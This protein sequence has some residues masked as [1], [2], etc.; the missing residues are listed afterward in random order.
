MGPVTIQGVRMLRQW[1]SAVAALGEL[2]SQHGDEAREEAASFAD[3]YRERRAAMVFDVVASRQRRYESR[4]V[5]MVTAFEATQQAGSLGYLAQHGPGGGFGLRAGEGETMR[6]TA[7]GLVSYCE[8]HGL[9]EEAGVRQWAQGT[10]A[11]AHA[12]KLDPYVGCVQGIGP[13]LFAYLRMRCGADAIKPDSRVR[14]GLNTAGFDIPDDEHAILIV[15]T[16]VADE[17]KIPVLVLDQL[18]WWQS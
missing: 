6:Q 2:L 14:K 10:A 9:D 18:L 15:A 8:S 7:A 11:F 17:L 16:A 12:P 5:P 13:A 4:V 1:P 3:T